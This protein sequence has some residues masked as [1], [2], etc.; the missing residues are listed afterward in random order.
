[1]WPPRSSSRASR[2]CPTRS[3]AALAT[4]RP[5]RVVAIGLRIALAR[6]GA[7]LSD[8]ETPLAQAV[9]TVLATRSLEDETVR[10]A[11]TTLLSEPLRMRA[12]MPFFGGDLSALA[13]AQLTPHLVRR[14][15]VGARPRRPRSTPFARREVRGAARATDVA[16]V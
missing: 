5:I 15:R 2:R 8:T 1:V 11:F 6:C 12:E 14:A 7:P 13:L 4:E 3:L 16:R 9:T 10:R